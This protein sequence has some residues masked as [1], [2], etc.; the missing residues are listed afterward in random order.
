MN[1]GKKPELCKNTQLG[2]AIVTMLASKNVG[3]FLVR[4]K[5]KP[6]YRASLQTK[7]M[8]KAWEILKFTATRTIDMKYLAEDLSFSY[9]ERLSV[10]AQMF[11]S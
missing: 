2:L 8:L 7:A 11:N 10:I 9:L 4:E 6:Q 5:E 3:I 1:S